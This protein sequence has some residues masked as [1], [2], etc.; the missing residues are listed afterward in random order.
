MENLE[1]KL[2]MS[3]WLD[4]YGGLLTERQ[5]KFMN[6]YY[7][8]DFSYGEIAESE[9]ISRQAVHDT[10]HHAKAALHHFESELHLAEAWPVASGSEDADRKAWE[11]VR[12]LV[13]ELRSMVR[14]D[15]LYDT[16]PLKRKLR[17]LCELV[18]LGETR[19]HV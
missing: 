8:E 4:V 16:G 2:K 3:A 11:S 19:T 15:I 7:N 5:R 14:D 13:S 6:L 17:Q 9:N 18:G 1:D 10:I 12:A